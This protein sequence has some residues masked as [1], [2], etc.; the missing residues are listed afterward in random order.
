MVG[1]LLVALTFSSALIPV[2][3]AG[4]V[5][6]RAAI[7]ASVVWAVIFSLATFTVRAIIA[8]V[9]KSENP[10]RPARVT[11]ALSLTVVAAAILLTMANALP[12]LAAVAV[13]PSALV[14]L[15]CGLLRVHPR[16]LRKMG[17]SLVVSNLIAFAALLFGLR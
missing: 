6:P 3:L 1:E 11:V 8:S 14:G 5:N 7:I 13:M 16:H 4:S 10:G 17:W 12:P 2:A 15:G 9:K